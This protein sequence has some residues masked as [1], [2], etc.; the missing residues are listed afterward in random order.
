MISGCIGAE[1]YKVSQGFNDIESYKNGAINLALP[2]LG[3]TLPNPV[4]KNQSKDFDPLL[5]CPIKAIPEDFTIYDKIVVQGPMTLEEL[6]KSL[7]EKY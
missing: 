5:G 2:L 3:F 4:V 1:I 7:N 6:M